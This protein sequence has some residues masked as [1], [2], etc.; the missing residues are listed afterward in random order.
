MIPVP[1]ARGPDSRRAGTR[2]SPPRLLGRL[3]DRG[4]VERVGRGLYRANPAQVTVT[5]SKHS[6]L[7]SP[8]PPVCP[9]SQRVMLV[10]VAT[11][12]PL[13]AVQVEPL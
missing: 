12:V 3:M 1:R 11:T 13:K 7:F 9:S 5:K 10:P 6:A 8:L 4:L 2:R